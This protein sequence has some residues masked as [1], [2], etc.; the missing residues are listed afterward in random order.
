MMQAR[1]R[2][3]SP[4]ARARGRTPGPRILIV[5]DEP[6][7]LRALRINLRARG[8]DVA[9]ASTGRDGARPRRRGS[10]RTPSSSTS[11]CPTWTAPR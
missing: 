7:L 4:P 6:A 8:Y 10:R 1:G 5:E 9:T 3:V 2:P 11:G